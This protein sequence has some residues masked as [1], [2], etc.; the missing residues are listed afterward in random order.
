[1]RGRERGS[2]NEEPTTRGRMESM[3]IGSLSLMERLQ[4]IRAG[5][6]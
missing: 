3:E 1:M 4:P 6:A 5:L 2:D